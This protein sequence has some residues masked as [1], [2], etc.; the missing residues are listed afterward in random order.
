MNGLKITF[1]SQEFTGMDSWN[2]LQTYCSK[3]ARDANGSR[4]KAARICEAA[5]GQATPEKLDRVAN[6]NF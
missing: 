2:G 4:R 3:M 5:I 6:I 1:F